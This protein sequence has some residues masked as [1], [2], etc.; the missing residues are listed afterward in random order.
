MRETTTLDMGDHRD[1]LSMPFT[2]SP[3]GC[4]SALRETRSGE[5]V[6]LFGGQ[7]SDRHQ[8]LEINN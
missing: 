4:Q 1:N 6:V 5:Q 2:T 8:G 7:D 3:A